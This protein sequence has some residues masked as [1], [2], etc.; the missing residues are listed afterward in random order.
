MWNNTWLGWECRNVSR[1]TARFGSISLGTRLSQP[2]SVE[3]RCPGLVPCSHWTTPAPFGADT[4]AMSCLITHSLS[5]L[6]SP[7][8]TGTHLDDGHNARLFAVTVV[9]EGLLPKFHG[10]QEIPCLSGVN[11]RLS[12]LSI[13]FSGRNYKQPKTGTN[14]RREVDVLQNYSG[15]VS[16]S[17]HRDAFVLE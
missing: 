14:K 4:Q 16:Y 10:P 5:P 3:L 2:C 6:P 7:Q 17:C 13:K 8:N 1:K 15:N 9:E 11:K 12:A